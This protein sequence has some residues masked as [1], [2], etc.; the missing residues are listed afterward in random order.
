MPHSDPSIVEHLTR[1]VRMMLDQT[2]E[3]PF[4]VLDCGVGV[5]YVGRALR[6]SEYSTPMTIKGIEIFAPYVEDGPVR[7]KLEVSS[8]V[9]HHLYDEV[10][11][12][13]FVPYLEEA[14]PRSVHAVIF[15]NS[16]EYIA[17][18]QAG[19]TLTK[20]RRVAK[21]GVVVTAPI[22]VRPQ[23]AVLGDNRHEQRLHWERGEWE[24]R[25]GIFLGGNRFLGGNSAVGC[26]LFPP[27]V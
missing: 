23:A 26:F 9:F 25:G 2:A 18:E 11:I 1:A 27:R 7:E 14:E 16:L 19:F 17:P 4:T 21:C 22:V 20:A 13:D 10:I 8:G 3:R 12:G 15:G 5:G 24:R 6:T